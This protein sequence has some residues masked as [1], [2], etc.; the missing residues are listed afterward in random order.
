MTPMSD[1][2]D[3]IDNQ[4]R[5]NPWRRLPWTVLLSLI[6]WTALTWGFG[7]LINTNMPRRA[8]PTPISMDMQLI[9]IQPPDM[10]PPLPHVQTNPSAETAPPALEIKKTEPKPKPKKAAPAP[11]PPETPAQT[12][13]L[14]PS[15]EHADSRPE[16][17]FKSETIDNATIGDNITVSDN[18][19]AT[20]NTTVVNAAS[21]NDNNSG[22]LFINLD[23]PNRISL[24]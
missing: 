23:Y 7:F 21:Q 1:K 15:V 11:A 20:D 2:V 5:D 13:K 16:P 22:P 18:A 17:I 14:V 12:A 6:I 19:T 3:T 24:Y 8:L 9:E 4:R 10:V